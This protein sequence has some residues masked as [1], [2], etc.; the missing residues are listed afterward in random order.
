MTVWTDFLAAQGATL[1]GETVAT[2]GAPVD[3]LLAAR[4]GAV[5]ADLSHYGLIG[6][7]GEEAQTFLH[8]LISNDLRNLSENAAVFA[9]YLSP[10]G[11]MLANF[12]VLK[13]G[14]D[15]LVLLPAALREAIQKRL[16]MYILRAKVK[17]RDASAEWVR[18]GLSGPGSAA[19]VAALLGKA[20]P[21]GAMSMAH[22]ETVFALRLGEQRFDLFVAP[23]AAPA[24]W[25]ALAATQRPVGAPAWDWL[26]VN[27]GIPTVL[28]ATQDHFVPQ[29]ANME[30]LGGVSFN[31]GCYPGQEIVARSQYLGKVKRRLYLA[32]VDAEAKI[33]DEL[34]SP[35]LA[36]QSTGSV[37]NVARAPGGGY[38]V[39]AVAHSSSVEAGVVHLGRRDG[40]RL[41]FRPLPYP[42]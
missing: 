35:D 26:L 17:A 10:K 12:L 7:A 9:A 29:M 5:L 27:A 4:D 40:P 22:A 3:E 2:F 6:F 37:A 39:L 19:A 11:R 36:D 24:A 21:A 34:F 41:A 1:E 38:D 15:L 30:V 42:V 32:H 8:A 25:A 33:G 31:K 14:G 13:R 18:L 16:S 20:V 28:P 23:A